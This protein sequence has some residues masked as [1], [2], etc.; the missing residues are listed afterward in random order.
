MPGP[1]P[2]T[3]TP[4][5]GLV[6]SH[7][8]DKVPASSAVDLLDVDWDARGVLGSRMGAT[9]FSTE[10][11]ATNYDVLFG[12][13]TEFLPLGEK[14][15]L[16]ARRGE[17][18][19]QIGEN[20]K[21]HGGTIAVTPL[22]LNFCQMGRAALTPI[23]YIA[24]QDKKVRKFE[25]E[26]FSEPTATVDGA[27]GQDMPICHFLADWQD[28]GNRLVYANLGLL[29]SPAGAAGSPSHVFFSNPGEPEHFESTAF[30]ELNPGDGQ[31]ILGMCTWGRQLF[32]FK[33]TY[34]A[35]FYGISE[36]PEGKPIFNFEIVDLGTRAIAPRGSGPPHVV[37]GREG[38][39][40]VAEDGIWVTT[41][42]PPTLVTDGLDL[43]LSRRESRTE[44]GKAAFPSWLHVKGLLY[45]A[46][47]LYVGIQEGVAESTEQDIERV[48]KIDIETGRITYWQTSLNAFMRWGQTFNGTPRIFFS[49]SGA[50][51]GVYFYTPATNLDPTV[52]MDP[53][54][55]SGGYDVE[56]VDEK[57]L[58]RV[59][60]WGS[61][62]VDLAVSEDYGAFGN[63]TTLDLG[64][65]PAEVV[66][67]APQKQQTATLFAH[68]FSGD[69]PWAIQRFARYLRETRV[70]ETQKG[71]G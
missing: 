1:E 51:K 43:S 69:A 24:N 28:E 49:G 67:S 64:A 26:A 13:G 5:G 53:Y 41:G 61:G 20:G 19:V 9:K 42:G 38:V 59:K 15:A 44:L 33:E 25:G 11:Q 10:D 22:R 6:L 30:V 32:V 55:E 54:F 62:T 2:I 48:F 17:V 36:G 71:A 58:I 27:G 23:T 29:G 4:T 39:Y 18:L 65:S 68:R 45:A 52:E 31:Q 34:F 56:D 37:A 47:C 8:F 63:P 16:L 3:L 14:F 70:S 57:T 50:N 60:A 7:P 46:G 66:Q 12:A 40:F 21:E 35:R